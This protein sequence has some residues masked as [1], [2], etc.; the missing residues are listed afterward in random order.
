[1]GLPLSQTP[2]DADAYLAWEAD[3]P[4]KSE[5]VAGE[6]FAMAARSQRR[7]F[8]T[9]KRITDRKFNRMR[10]SMSR[11]WGHETRLALAI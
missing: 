8:F 2:F 4:E 5:Y 3:Q 9:D 1:M 11:V 10:P 6:G 7:C